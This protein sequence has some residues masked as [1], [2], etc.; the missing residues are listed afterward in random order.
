MKDIFSTAAIASASAAYRE[1]RQLHAIPRAKP[2]GLN[3]TR[4]RNQRQGT[5]SDVVIGGE[6]CNLAKAKQR[7]TGVQRRRV[8]LKEARKLIESLDEPWTSTKVARAFQVYEETAYDWLAKCAARYGY[9]AEPGPAG[10][11]RRRT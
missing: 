11:F 4:T 5:T 9:E 6:L 1:P 8:T 2:L 3:E 10:G 7:D